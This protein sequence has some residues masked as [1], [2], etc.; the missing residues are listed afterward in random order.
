MQLSCR[1]M[2][3]AVN[4]REKIVKCKNC[5]KL[6]IYKIK[7]GKAENKPV[8]KRNCSSGVTFI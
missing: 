5:N 4:Y 7:T 3:W 8:P 1:N 2:G 6:V